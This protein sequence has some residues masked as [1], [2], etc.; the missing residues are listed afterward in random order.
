[1]EDPVQASV[2]A[3]GPGMPLLPGGEAKN[4]CATRPL[5][6]VCWG[7]DTIERPYLFEAW[8]E[9]A[10]PLFDTVPTSPEPAFSGGGELA[11]IGDMVF[12]R[13]YFHP[14]RFVRERG[15]LG[16][17]DGISLQFYVSG[18]SV[19]TRGGV[20]Y[21]MA[22]DRVGLVDFGHE[23]CGIARQQS[24]VVGINFPREQ[25]DLRPF[26]GR[27]QVAW[28]ADSAPGRL[29]ISGLRHVH[30][31]LRR[32]SM[33]HAADISAGFIGLINGLLGSRR[34]VCPPALVQQVKLAAIEAYIHRNLHDRSLGPAMLARQFG[35]SRSRLYDLFRERGGVDTYLRE[36]R[37]A[38]CFRDL[39]AAEPGPAKVWKIATRWGFDDPSNFHRLFKRRFNIRPSDLLAG[40]RSMMGESQPVRTIPADQLRL[41]HDWFRSL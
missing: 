24:E 36:C 30:G 34:E 18:S 26:S 3:D 12:T 4:H 31:E 37:L 7:P 5:P 20:C 38:R 1:M 25:I 35:C 23:Y 21:K 2:T 33:D 9:A 10:R 15:H 32:L 17:T 27:P 29:L 19:G 13:A 8:H 16:K 41:A 28:P 6:V 40:D 11:K 22:P 14:Q 39:A